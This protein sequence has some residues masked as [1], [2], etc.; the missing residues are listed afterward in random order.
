MFPGFYKAEKPA[1]PAG[2]SCFFIVYDLIN[3]A[4]GRHCMN[5]PSITW[6]I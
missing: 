1:E 2:F 6:L 5:V 3:A 4:D